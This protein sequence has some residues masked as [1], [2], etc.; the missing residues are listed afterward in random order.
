MSYLDGLTEEEWVLDPI[1]IELPRS[2]EA[3]MDELAGRNWDGI[4]LILRGYAGLRQRLPSA[5]DAQCLD[6][7]MVWY[8]G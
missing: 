4:E 3:L 2:L 6:T 8:F 5:T 1:S 7:S